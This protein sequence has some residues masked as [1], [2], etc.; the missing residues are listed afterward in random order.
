[1]YWHLN[2][3]NIIK[4]IKLFYINQF[5]PSHWYSTVSAMLRLSTVASFLFI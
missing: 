3:E 1:M 5:L 4:K 2:S